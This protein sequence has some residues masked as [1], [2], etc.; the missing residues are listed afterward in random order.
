[1]LLRVSLREGGL[2]TLV[3]R[4]TIEEEVDEDDMMAMAI[5]RWRRLDRERRRQL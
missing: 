4:T 1:M 5:L 2:P 3:E